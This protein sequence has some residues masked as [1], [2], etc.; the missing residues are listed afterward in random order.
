[1][2]AVEMKSG[3]PSGI[4]FRDSSESSRCLSGGRHLGQSIVLAPTRTLGQLNEIIE[5]LTMLP[6]VRTLRRQENVVNQNR[7]EPGT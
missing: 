2:L 5:S 4:A 7:S 1:M 3:V 6:S